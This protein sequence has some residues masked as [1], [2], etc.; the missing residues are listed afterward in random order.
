[1]ELTEVQKFQVREAYEK[2]LS[3]CNQIK[4]KSLKGEEVDDMKI[5][6]RAVS[7]LEIF[8]IKACR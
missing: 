2:A 7:G 6:E 8:I 5:L 3:V 4:Q 1:M